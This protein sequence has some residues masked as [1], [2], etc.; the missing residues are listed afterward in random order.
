MKL[1]IDMNLSPM[2][3]EVLKRCEGVGDAVHWSTVGA[4]N[5]PDSALMAYAAQRDMIVL[6]HDLDFSAILAATRVSKPSVIQL[7]ANDVRPSALASQVNE[8]IT[9]FRVDL[10]QGALLTIDAERARVR[11]LPFP[12]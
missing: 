3:V 10:K 12:P 6:T 2:W 8:A 11:L 1:L 7:R 9:R 4:L 5:A